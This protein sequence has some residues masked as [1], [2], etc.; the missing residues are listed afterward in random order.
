MKARR[1]SMTPPGSPLSVPLLG[2]LLIHGA[3]LLLISAAI[4]R[5]R[6]M[7][8]DLIPIA[9]LDM[10]R[11][12][13]DNP[14]PREKP[15]QGVKK[16]APKSAKPVLENQIAETQRPAAFKEQ[17]SPQPAETKPDSG[18]KLAPPADFALA[19]DSEG[20]GGT[21]VAGLNRGSGAPGLP[22]PGT[23]LRTNRQAKPTQTARPFYPPMALRIGLDGDVAL[24]IEV[25]T[26]GK[27]TQAEIVKS[28]GAGFDEA[29]LK[30]VKQSR[31]E[32]AQKDGQTVLAEFTYIYRFRLTR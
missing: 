16:P 32:P 2:S 28:A 5:S 20:G 17:P 26:D 27:V 3:A 10:P 21:A 12:Y 1:L 13:K 18:A 31:F 9:L 19:A 11:L 4:Q 24:K 6:S 7:R 30:A 23:V 14:T 29:A 15:P 8:H 22:T 25:D